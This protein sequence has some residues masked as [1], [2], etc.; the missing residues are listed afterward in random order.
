M[1]KAAAHIINA[2]SSASIIDSK[3]KR[4]IPI[5]ITAKIT[6]NNPPRAFCTGLLSLLLIALISFL[7]HLYNQMGNDKNDD[8]TNN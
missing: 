5:S 4:G 8:K 2:Q 7:T 1:R 6:P 3:A